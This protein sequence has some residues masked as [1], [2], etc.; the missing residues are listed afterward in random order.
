LNNL[1]GLFHGKGFEINRLLDKEDLDGRLWQSKPSGT[2]PWY[3]WSVIK[4]NSTYLECCDKFFGQ[5]GRVSFYCLFSLLT[6]IGFLMAID[7]EFFTNKLPSY[8]ESQSDSG[9]I[10][11]TIFLH[12]I[13]IPLIISFWRLWRNEN[14]RYTHYPMRFNRKTRMVHFFRLDGSIESDLDGMTL[15]VPWDKLFFTVLPGSRGYWDVRAHYLA[16]NRKTVLE[17]FALAH[18]GYK[19]ALYLLSQWEFIRRY[20]EEGPQELAD[21]I[22][23]VVDVDG[24]RETFWIGYRRLQL[25]LGLP[26][27]ITTLFTPVTFLEAIG[28]WIA[29]RTCKIPVWPEEIEAQCQIE[30]GDPYIRDAEHLADPDAA[31]LCHPGYANTQRFEQH[32]CKAKPK[33][34]ESQGVQNMAN[35][36]TY[37][38]IDFQKPG[39]SDEEVRQ[40]IHELMTGDDEVKISNET[41]E[42]DLNPLIEYAIRRRAEGQSGPKTAKDLIG[43]GLS[44]F[45]ADNIVNQ[46]TRL[47]AQTT[48][49]PAKSKPIFGKVIA[50]VVALGLLA[51]FIL[52][53]TECQHIVIKDL[54]CDDPSFQTNAKKLLLFK[55]NEAAKP[56][57]STERLMD[58]YSQRNDSTLTPTVNTLKLKYLDANS[59]SFSDIETIKS[60]DFPSDEMSDYG[61]SCAATAKVTLSK[62]ITNKLRQ[63]PNA[64]AIINLQGN[65]VEFVIIYIKRIDKNGDTLVG[66]TFEHPMMDMLRSIE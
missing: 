24:H 2:E 4:M 46:A 10:Y 22:D 50:A 49:T 55:I 53:A 16:D 58:P 48:A 20:M 15:S 54:G 8:L 39:P 65:D 52:A 47:F 9:M 31:F 14:F 64:A 26:P 19:D 13:F 27:L 29:M 1:D 62:N 23:L 37:I 28:R 18:Y 41:I 32:Q 63:T 59:V 40:A 17:T 60:P 21:Q 51:F 42:N 6:M 61:H 38:A 11:V 34:E 43:K 56:K 7:I 30:P 12:I 35:N 33:E 5:K 44:A 3:Q 57:T 45:L 25:E 36:T 66:I